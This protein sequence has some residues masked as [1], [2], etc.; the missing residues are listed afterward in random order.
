MIG[1]HPYKLLRQLGVSQQ[2]KPAEKSYDELTTVLKQHLVP[3]PIVI[4]ER[5]K[6][7]KHIQK[8]GEKLV[9][10]RLFSLRKLSQKRSHTKVPTYR[11]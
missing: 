5:L 1:S 6:F 4:A 9:I 11:S 7:H 10:I 3:K 8:P 2:I